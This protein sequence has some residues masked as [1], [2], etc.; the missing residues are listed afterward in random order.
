MQSG[1]PWYLYYLGFN[2]DTSV[3]RMG[4]LRA[5]GR[6]RTWWR[7]MVPP[8]STKEPLL[9]TTTKEEAGG[10]P[11]RRMERN[12]L[13]ITE[14]EMGESKAILNSGIQAQHKEICI[15]I[16]TGSIME[17]FHHS[18]HCCTP[19]LPLGINKAHFNFRPK[20]K[21]N[22]DDPLQRVSLSVSNFVQTL[23]QMILTPIQD[24]GCF[25]D[26][27][28]IRSLAMR[29]V[30]QSSFPGNLSLW[31][32]ENRKLINLKTILR[33]MLDV[34]EGLSILHWEGI[35][36]RD[37]KPENILLYHDEGNTIRAKLAGRSP[38]VL[39]W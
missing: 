12:L 1:E 22:W 2:N 31:S 32:K 34:T 36:H 38:K 7:F 23:F 6:W 26:P 17:E 28:S 14:E 39:T 37:I 18:I 9:L 4:V 10:E 19:S 33:L 25:A 27:Q 5:W 20:P 8:H 30:F 29:R 3:L 16:P 24:V 35:L 21:W 13:E 11:L 15:R